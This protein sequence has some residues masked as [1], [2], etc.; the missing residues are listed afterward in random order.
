LIIDHYLIQ[1]KVI[2]YFRDWHCIPKTLDAAAKCLAIHPLF[3]QSS[4]TT[5][6]ILNKRSRIPQD[7]QKDL[8]KNSKKKVNPDGEAK[9][10]VAED[11]PITFGDSEEAL[12][13]IVNEGALGPSMATANMVKG[14][15][16]EVHQ[17][18]YTHMSAL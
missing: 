14:W 1:H 7:I 4:K 2:S 5:S 13:D 8:R 15:S 9:V 16:T 12:K 3:W 17:F 10:R 18:A 11:T 6:K